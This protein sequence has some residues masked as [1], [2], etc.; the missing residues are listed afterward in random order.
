MSV[1]NSLPSVAG[2]FDYYLDGESHRAVDRAAAEKL[3][4]LFPRAPLVARENRAFLGRVVRC[5]V[6]RGI[7]QFI[8]IGAGPP[9]RENV[10][11]VARRA[12]PD[13]RVVC[14]DNDPLVLARSRSLLAEDPQTIVVDAD[15]CEPEAIINRQQVRAHIDFDR[16]VAVLMFASLHFVSDHDAAAATVARLREPLVSG[17]G[18][19]ISHGYGGNMSHERRRVGQQIYHST[20]TGGSFTFRSID[21]IAGYFD[22]LE[23]LEPGIVPVPGWR[24]EAGD[25]AIDFVNPSILGGVA[26]V[27]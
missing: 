15:L 7:R 19:A 5:L 10:Q 20:A 9:T 16:P 6:E 4:E 26:I 24:P 21:Q 12:A 18:L 1:N 11:Q 8:D 23:I 27:P 22:G 17:S 13:S 2:I 3:I 14:V 25:V